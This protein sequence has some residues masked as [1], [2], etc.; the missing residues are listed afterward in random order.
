MMS[1]GPNPHLWG[2]VTDPEYDKL[3]TAAISTTSA[4]ERRS[5]Y[6]KA[7]D[8]V[9]KNYYTVVI[10]HSPAAY[11]IR[12]EVHDLTVGFNTSAHRVDG[13]VAFA[14]LSE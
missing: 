8:R 12:N 2:G 13:G 6:L 11:G 3:V 10:G 4:E 14:W 5:S 7:W 9:M 1:D